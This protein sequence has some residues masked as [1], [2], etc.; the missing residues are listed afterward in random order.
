MSLYS[1]F[2]K[3]AC[4]EEEESMKE[5]W[6]I[7]QWL[8]VLILVSGF[9]LLV[10]GCGFT[11]MYGNHATPEGGPVETA[12]TQVEIENIPDREG[13]YLRN[14]LIDRFYRN[15]RPSAPRYRL[16]VNPVQESLI[17][18]DI[19]KS[20]DSTR[21]QLRLTTS[22]NLVDTQ[23][24]ESVLTRPLQSITS[25]NILTSE[26]AT[27]VTED[28]ARMNALDD[29]AR[30]IELQIGLFLERGAEIKGTE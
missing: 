28:N 1:D 3:G 22:M 4:K 16:S 21:G 11:P 17:D 27:R 2:R 13:Q 25:Y 23:S 9:S 15:G 12:L 26:F 14:A 20:S 30:Q 19:T 5:S 7:G 8:S 24:G 29:L 18:L 10:S 6:V